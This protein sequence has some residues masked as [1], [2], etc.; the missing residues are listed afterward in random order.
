MAS[1]LVSYCIPAYNAEKTIARCLGGVLAQGVDDAEIVLIDNC[2][3]DRTVEVAREVLAGRSHVQIL[4]NPSNLGRIGNW[5]RC[6]EEARGKYTKFALTNDVLFGDATRHFLHLAEEQADTVMVC[7]RPRFVD[8]MPAAVP[9]MDVPPAP[10]RRAAVET[11]EFFA[12]NGFRTGSLNGMLYRREPIAEH[13]L[14]FREDIP[15]CADYHQAIELAAHGSSVFLNTDSYCFNAGVGG[16]FH[17]VGMQD[18]KRFFAEQRDC[19]VLMTHLLRSI[20]GCHRDAFQYLYGQYLWHLGQGTRLTLGVAYAAFRGKP[21]L[22][23][24][25]TLKTWRHN[26]VQHDRQTRR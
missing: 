23:V 8:G 11:L 16:R 18:P 22:L 4:V 13:R 9:A 21:G 6:L 2:S 1:P 15:Y 5:N 14:L 10:V 26:R 25:A 7:S 20:G 24:P 12:R 3:T 17:Y 19:A